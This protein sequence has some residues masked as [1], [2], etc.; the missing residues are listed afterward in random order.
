MMNI[1]EIQFIVV[2][3]MEGSRRRVEACSINNGNIQ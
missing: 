2:I 3:S 1:E